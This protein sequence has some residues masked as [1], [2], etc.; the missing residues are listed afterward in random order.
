M[1]NF[2]RVSQRSL[3]AEMPHEGGERSDR[4]GAGIAGKLAQLARCRQLH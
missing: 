2:T 1:K 3:F 4:G